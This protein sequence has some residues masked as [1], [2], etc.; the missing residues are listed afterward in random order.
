MAAFPVADCDEPLI[1]VH[2][3]LLV[4]D[5]RADATSS[6]AHLRRGVLERFVRAQSLLPDGLRLLCV[7]GYRPPDL[8]QRY[9]EESDGARSTDARTAPTGAPRWWGS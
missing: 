2:G 3:T 8:Q 5:R 4:D 9:F 1:D 6:Y 7:E